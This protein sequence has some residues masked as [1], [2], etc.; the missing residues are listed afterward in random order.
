MLSVL[1]QRNFALLW[2]GGLISMTGDWLLLIGLPVYVYALTGSTWVTGSVFTAGF[3]PEILLGSVAGVFADRW[4][5]RR[6]M[7]VS[8]LL[9]ALTLLPL[10]AVASRGQLWIVYAVQVV[11]SVLSQFF[12]P[13]EN[14]LLPRVVGPAPEDLL[15]ANALLSLGTNLARLVG[16]PLGGIVAAL[17]GL[18][19]IVLLDVASFLVAAALIAP[20]RVATP[21]RAPQP[22]HATP[23][24]AT[25]TMELTTSS[26]TH[27]TVKVRVYEKLSLRRWERRLWGR[28]RLARP[29]VASRTGETPAPPGRQCAD[30]PVTVD[31]VEKRGSSGVRPLVGAAGGVWR[32]W[33][34]GL[35]LVRGEQTIRTVFAITAIQQVAQGIFVVLFI[36]F[37]ERVLRGS[38]V[39][40]GWLRGVQAVG[41]LL[42]GA[43]IG[44]FGKRV[45]ARRLIGASGILFG[46]ICL[47]IWNAPLLFPAYL[48]SVALF[49]AVGIPG[50]GLGTGT[51]T[52]LQTSVD[53][54]YRGRI[55]GAFT[56]TSALLQLCGMLLAGALGDRLGVLP[57]LDAQGALYI[58]AGL[59]ALLF[60]PREQRDSV[61]VARARRSSP[62]TS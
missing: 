56:T 8:T 3:V 13:A 9:Q 31:A 43:V 18:H 19:G 39:E 7:L 11:A 30:L 22:D 48:L 12:A 16:S 20:V 62:P 34:L 29:R 53:D 27:D 14:A 23:V 37:V 42:G 28:G 1:R 52:L 26:A 33:L 58:M 5:R 6:T 17:L 25:S 60:L 51:M 10:L 45:A 15:A 2:C 57:V 55:F 35:R 41:G 32:E 40:V 4:D 50:V 38:S 46:L 36:V 61:L 44:A 59:V 47:A 54:A 49:V 21:E 24:T